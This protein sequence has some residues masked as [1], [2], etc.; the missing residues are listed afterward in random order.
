[1]MKRQGL[2]TRI[3][4]TELMSFAHELDEI[5]SVIENEK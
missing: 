2:E 1:M 4:K 5:Q 3:N